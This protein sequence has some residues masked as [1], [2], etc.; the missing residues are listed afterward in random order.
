M[1]RR[2]QI[3]AA[4]ARTTGETSGPDSVPMQSLRLDLKRLIETDKGFPLES[5]E[6]GSSERQLAFCGGDLPGKGY[7]ID[8]EPIDA[9]MLLVGLWLVR[10]GLTQMRAV[11]RT[12]QLRPWLERECRSRLAAIAENALTGV[13][14]GELNH[15][16]SGI[17]PML[18]EG[19]R[20][21]FLL[22]SMG[23]GEGLRVSM[24]DKGLSNL[25]EGTELPARLA[26]LVAQGPI[27][28]LDL[29]NA[30]SRLCYWLDRIPAV[31]RGRKA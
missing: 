29:G 8:Y 30:W 12:R 24:P 18:G 6:P 25:V 1:Y 7:E 20:N 5:I 2:N 16:A 19:S 3:E 4:I 23:T 31:R 17:R 28:V 9:L 21:L 11:R 27:L 22:I 14:A 13:D 15:R 10:G 26:E